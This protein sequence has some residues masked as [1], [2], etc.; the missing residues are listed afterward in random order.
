MISPE[1]APAPD[2]AGERRGAHPEEAPT[3]SPDHRHRRLKNR[4]YHRNRNRR[5]RTTVVSWNAEGLRLKQAE[6]ERWLPTVNADVVAIQEAQLPKVAPRLIGFH[7]PVVVRRARGRTTGAAPKGGDVC[8]YVRAGRHFD[9][10]EGRMLADSDDSTEI[11]GVRL[12]SQPHLDI[13]NI[14]RP[15]IRAT[16]DDRQDHFDP[17]R[18]PNDGQTLL[19]GD[20]NGHHPS[21]DESCTTAD[22]VGERLAA[23]MEDVEWRPLNIGAATFVRYRSGCETAPDFAAGSNSLAT[24]IRWTLGTD[25]GSDHRPMVV[26]VRS[27]AEPPHRR[28]KSRWAHQKA[29]WLK[30]GRA[31]ESPLSVPAP[32][33]ATVQQMATRLTATIQEAAKEHIP[34]EPGRTRSPGQ[35]I[36]RLYR[37]SRRGVKPEET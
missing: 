36:Q 21:W 35:P 20:V 25:L 10:L 22:P 37:Q 19:V 6:L 28:R 23:W 27:P 29:D 24:R 2:R 11:C 1:A 34:A 5:S 9:V 3:N 31:C 8:I 4:R 16:N 17:R 18:L 7:P 26:E 30:F 14:Y 33:E 12:L 15:P 13:I 32:P